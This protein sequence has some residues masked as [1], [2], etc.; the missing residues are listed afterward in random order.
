MT[1]STDSEGDGAFITAIDSEMRIEEE[2]GN[3]SKLRGVQVEYNKLMSVVD[4]FG[5]K[6]GNMVDKQRA[7]YMQAYEH[8]MLDVQR[9]LHLLRDKVTE[10]ANDE[11]RSDKLITL[12]SDEKFYKNEALTY[13]IETNELRK[14]LRVLTGKM[15][16]IEK[17]RDWLLNKLKDAKMKYKALETK[18]KHY[19]FNV[20]EDNGSLGSVSHDSSY[21]LELKSRKSKST[22]LKNKKEYVEDNNWREEL[23]SSLNVS[24]DE[25]MINALPL[26]DGGNG[27]MNDVAYI[28]QYQPRVPV[29]KTADEKWATGQL[30]QAR[31]KQESIRDLVDHCNKTCEDGQWKSID[32]RGL[33]DLLEDCAKLCESM[34]AG[35]TPQE[36][37]HFQIEFARE[38]V[39]YPETYWA[40]SDLMVSSGPAQ[41]DEEAQNIAN[42]YEMKWSDLETLPYE[43]LSK[44]PSE[45]LDGVDAIGNFLQNDNGQDGPSIVLEGI[46]SQI[47]SEDSN[48]YNFSIANDESNPLD[49]GI[50]NRKS[51][52]NIQTEQLALAD[53]L[54]NYLREAKSRKNLM[55]NSI[56][57]VDEKIEQE[58]DFMRWD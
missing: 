38:L 16:T 42:G 32:R 21:T 9:E 15:Q 10:I 12:S 45:E 19:Q 17:E 53:D 34:D 18:R 35:L 36:V 54:V 57:I 13:D 40:I 49:L 27:D 26:L 55:N 48:L 33:P 6:V 52:V 3:E 7:E 50:D 31:A 23:N 14:K 24:R 22:S 1:N 11:T 47:L 29:R 8:H 4:A 44:A 2:N 56:N 41:T 30:V 43:M 20:N 5:S 25:A 58:D 39:I 46:G 37:R 51:K 28:Q